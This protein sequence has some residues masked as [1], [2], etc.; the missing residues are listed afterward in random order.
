VLS[1]VG[2]E[3]EIR[4]L[5][6]GGSNEHEPL[7]A[8]GAVLT[9]AWDHYAP[10]WGEGAAPPCADLGGHDGMFLPN[11]ARLY[12]DHGYVEYSTPECAS[13]AD[14]VA[15]V[16]AGDLIVRSAAEKA[17]EASPD[18]PRIA[19]FR[20]N[21]DYAPDPHSCGAHVNVRMSRKG[22]ESI[23][24]DP[25]VLHGFVVPFFVSLP[26]ICGSGTIA[27]HGEGEGFGIWQRAPF[28]RDLVA[29][30]TTFDR[31]LVNTRDESLAAD[32]EQYARF[33]V[34]AFDA[35]V[36]ET[37]EFCKLGLLRLLCAAIDAER[38]DVT[39]E[40]EDPMA[41]IRSVSRDPMAPVRMG[42]QGTITPVQ[43]LGTYLVA[44]ER[45][46]NEG[47]FIGRV[48]DARE[49]LNHCGEVLGQLEH[50]P[51]ELVG[52]LDWP[53]KFAWLERIR[54]R[55]GLEW[56]DPVLKLADVEYHHVTDGEDPGVVLQRITTDDQIRSLVTSAPTG[57]RAEVRGLLIRR[58]AEEITGA[59]WS[60]L[61]S[62][63]EASLLVLPDDPP[64]AAAQKL[65]SAK[66]LGD[67]A[68]ELGLESLGVVP[69]FE[70]IWTAEQPGEKESQD[71]ANAG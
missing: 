39:P 64:P 25:K 58:F 26:V 19:A 31:P 67:A 23:F 40:L 55:H 33:H 14:A 68:G 3:S 10:S 63:R 18:V 44:F 12:D 54:A 37:A 70:V 17:G 5:F 38:I 13:T 7:G 60:G 51:L 45:M 36:S 71:P 11:G 29:W 22:F 69:L 66:C 53:T 1:L 61:F 48:P 50:D 28:L 21:R 46:A 30:Q 24:T 59:D 65:E 62:G 32:P 41:A 8:A 34:I 43:L 35:N 52:V 20:N 47:V 42:S 57:S 16:R 6:A 9:A 4:V 2:V 56:S 15:A 27:D 49:I